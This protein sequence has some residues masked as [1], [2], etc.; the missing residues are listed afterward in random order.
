MPLLY[1][2]YT[3]SLEWGGSGVPS[4]RVWCAP[5]RRGGSGVPSPGKSGVPSPGESLVCLPWRGG[6]GVPSPGR[7]GVPSPGDSLVCFPWRRGSGVPSPG[8]E[9]LVCPLLQMLFLLSLLLFFSPG[10]WL[11]LVSSTSYGE[12]VIG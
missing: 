10:E 5:S 9:G 11:H 12:V 4:P 6:S 7:S 8:G 1:T 3:V 2:V